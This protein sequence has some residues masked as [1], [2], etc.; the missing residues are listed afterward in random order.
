MEPTSHPPPLRPARYVADC[1]KPPRWPA[2]VEFGVRLSNAANAPAP[3]IRALYPPPDTA[4]PTFGSC[5]VLLVWL[6]IYD[7]ASNPSI[8]TCPKK[9]FI[10]E[11]VLLRLSFNQSVSL[12][13]NDEAART[14]GRVLGQ[15]TSFGVYPSGA[16]GSALL[17]VGAVYSPTTAPL[18]PRMT[19]EDVSFTYFYQSSFSSKMLETQYHVHTWQQPRGRNYP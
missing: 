16:L 10:A 17:T 7:A 4:M 1:S 9:S 11:T 6:S 13:D 15:L 8:V 12:D 2:D 3:F 14:E 19:T 18:E 5:E